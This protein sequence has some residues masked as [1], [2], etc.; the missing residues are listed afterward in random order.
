MS[1]KKI[2]IANSNKPFKRSMVGE[3]AQ[4]PTYQQ[5]GGFG[6]TR[7]LEDSTSINNYSN[8]LHSRGDNLLERA[9]LSDLCELA[10][11]SSQ[12]Y[13][14]DIIGDY[15]LGASS[16]GPSKELSSEVMEN[17]DKS[18]QNEHDSGMFQ[19][20]EISKTD[21]NNGINLVLPISINGRK[22]D[23]IVDTGT[24][25]TVVNE[26]CFKNLKLPVSCAQVF[27][28]KGTGNNTCIKTVSG[29]TARFNIGNIETKWR[30][31]V[32]NIISFCK[33]AR[34]SVILLLPFFITDPVI[35]GRDLLHH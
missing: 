28:L 29:D 33:I 3:V 20:K 34:S 16:T 8:V 19:V 1:K 30:F 26:Y 9:G 7:K 35:I 13:A 15:V 32:A 23:G 14:K 17:K 24:Q 12:C 25:I 11:S 2:K 5:S 22:I 18:K 4:P 6:T 31:I 27:H 10:D 21:T